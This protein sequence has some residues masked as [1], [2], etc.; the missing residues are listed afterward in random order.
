MVYRWDFGDGTWDWGPTA[1]HTYTVSDLYWVTLDVFDDQGGFIAS[2]S[3]GVYVMG[4]A[5]P[6]ASLTATCSG[7]TCSF[8]G[9]SS[10]DSGGTIASY[11]WAF[12]DGDNRLRS[13]REPYLRRRGRVHGDVDRYR[14]RR[15]DRHRD[16]G[17]HG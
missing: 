9:S 8:D 12:G 10:S 5:P 2:H 1:S 7:L 14:Q 15:R 11:A 3:H 16:I 4:N 17:C 6:M 13:G